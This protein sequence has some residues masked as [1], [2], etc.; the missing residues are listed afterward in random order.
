MER[1]NECK[2]CITNVHLSKEEVEKLF[3][4][5]I[6]VRNIKT[7]SEDVYT[8]RLS[9]CNNCSALEY[10][11]TCKYCGCLIRIKTKIQN[12]KCPYPFDP[13]W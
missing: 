5:M 6:K 9:I 11:T 7:V 13:K 12:T 10:G 3:G 2:G 4:D 1:I 8:E